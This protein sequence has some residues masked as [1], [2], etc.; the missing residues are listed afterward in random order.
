MNDGTSFEHDCRYQGSRWCDSGSEGTHE[1]LLKSC[2]FYANLVR[3]WI[4]YDS[5]LFG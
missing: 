2:E 4:E 3:G 5:D 1:E